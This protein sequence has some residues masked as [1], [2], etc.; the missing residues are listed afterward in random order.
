MW[1]YF[2]GSILDGHTQILKFDYSLSIAFI[3]HN[4][5][6]FCIRLCHEKP[7]DILRMFWEIY[8][9][10]ATPGCM[11]Q[12]FPDKEKFDGRL[13]EFLVLSDSFTSQELFVIFTAAYEAMYD[14]EIDILSNKVIYWEPHGCSRDIFRDYAAWLEDEE[15]IGTTVRISRNEIVR[16]GS[17]LNTYNH[18]YGCLDDNDYWK[19][20]DS[21]SLFNTKG[22]S[23]S[24]W[25]EFTVRFED[26]KL[27]PKQVIHN[28]CDKIGIQWED[29]LLQTTHRGEISFYESTTGFSLRPVYDSYENYLSTFDRFRISLLY[30][31]IQKKYGYP[32][33]DPSS[34][35]RRELQAMFLKDFKFE[36]QIVLKRYKNKIFY[37]RQIYHS[38]SILLWKVRKNFLLEQIGGSRINA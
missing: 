9:A 35:S 19:N 10:E 26:L 16:Q 24:Y 1:Q 5:F 29:I 13:K 11:E 12:E 7:E 6:S 3:N 30:A 32:Y 34:F 14:T 17:I 4:L 25:K 38:L 18:F 36:K 15:I 31:Y 8:I 33:S 22:Y 28:I 21:T 27:V 2:F 20:L 23:G 37:K